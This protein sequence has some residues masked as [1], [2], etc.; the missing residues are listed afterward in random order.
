[1][2]VIE[3]SILLIQKF[4]FYK[5][6]IMVNNFTIWMFFYKYIIKIILKNKDNWIF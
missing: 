5:Q 1:M 4:N 2:Q 6:N 3:K